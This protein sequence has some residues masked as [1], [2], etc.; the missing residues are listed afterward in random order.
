MLRDSKL[1]RGLIDWITGGISAR[2]DFVELDVATL[3]NQTNQISKD[4]DGMAQVVI[5]HHQQLEQQQAQLQLQAAQ[6]IAMRR[7]HGMLAKRIGQAF[8]GK[9]CEVCGGGMVF[10]RVASEHA[11]SLQCPKGCAKRLLLPEGMILNS[12]RKLPTG[13]S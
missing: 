2:L 1:L 13:R 11:Y 9:S 8:P 6:L 4:Q 5:A 10:E 3:Q 7:M 12:L